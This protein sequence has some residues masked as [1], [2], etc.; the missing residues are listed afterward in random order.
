MLEL[1]YNNPV[2]VVSHTANETL[3]EDL[4]KSKLSESTIKAT[5]LEIDLL[6]FC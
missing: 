6:Y 4:N 5:Y 3:V 1:L 2:C